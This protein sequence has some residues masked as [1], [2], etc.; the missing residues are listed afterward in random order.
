MLGL[1][2]LEPNIFLRILCLVTLFPC[3]KR[4]VIRISITVICYIYFKMLSVN[5]NDNILM[6]TETIMN[7]NLT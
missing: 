7:A 1:P 3:G 2:F 6:Q 5:Y 4:S